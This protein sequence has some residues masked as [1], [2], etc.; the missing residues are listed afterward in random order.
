MNNA[1]SF[2]PRDFNVPK[3][4]HE[5]VGRFRAMREIPDPVLSLPHLCFTLSSPLWAFARILF[6]P[7]HPARLSLA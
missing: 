2:P 7:G 1:L 3:A 6:V 5:L 4:I